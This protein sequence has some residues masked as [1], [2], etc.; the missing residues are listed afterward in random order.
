M[1]T[2]FRARR[3][4]SIFLTKLPCPGLQIV[5]DPGQEVRRKALEDGQLSLWLVKA[6]T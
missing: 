4:K 1:S 2:E 5:L 3:A 6:R